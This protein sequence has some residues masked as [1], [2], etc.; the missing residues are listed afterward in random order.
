MKNTHKHSKGEICNWSI[1]ISYVQDF[2]HKMI[3]VM[4][5]LDALF[6]DSLYFI[7]IRKNRVA[8]NKDNPSPND[9]ANNETDGY[10]LNFFSW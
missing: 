8:A 5:L 6:L 4:V 3:C 2:M 10:K 1:K 9:D 7:A